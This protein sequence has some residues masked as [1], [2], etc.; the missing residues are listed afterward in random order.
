MGGG[1]VEAA[2]PHLGR[3]SM[4]GTRKM[5][6]RKRGRKGMGGNAEK[7]RDR[8]QYR[9]TKPIFKAVFLCR[10]GCPGTYYIDQ[11]G[12][13]LTASCLP[14]PQNVGIKSMCHHAWFTKKILI[15]TLRWRDLVVLQFDNGDKVRSSGN[16]VE[17]PIL[18][19]IMLQPLLQLSTPFY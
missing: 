11:A 10:H 7:R 14:L 4:K 1:K 16:V 19:G 18:L 6:E 5:N 12:L 13:E 2:S 15:F 17:K 3:L 8:E 9:C